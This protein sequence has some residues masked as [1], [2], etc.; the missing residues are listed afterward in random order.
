MNSDLGP[1]E[2]VL[3]A[4]A[5]PTFAT[6]SGDEATMLAGALQAALARQSSELEAASER[7]LQHVPR[8]LRGTVK[9]VVFG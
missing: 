2:R 9:R 7:A 3:R 1:L 5:P 8:V 4:T 6:L